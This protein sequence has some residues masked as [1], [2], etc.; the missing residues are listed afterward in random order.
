LPPFL[1]ERNIFPPS[2]AAGRFSPRG[3]RGIYGSS[4]RPSRR[5]AH[6]QLGGFGFSRHFGR[7]R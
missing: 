3:P 4:L 6:T 2:I 1:I 7:D 5:R